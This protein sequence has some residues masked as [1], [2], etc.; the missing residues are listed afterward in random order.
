MSGSQ[1]LEVQL[2]ALRRDGALE[3]EKQT[4]MMR[5]KGLGKVFFSATPFPFPWEWKPVH[6]WTKSDDPLV[7]EF[8]EAGFWTKSKNYEP[9]AV[10]FNR[11]QW[12]RVTT[13][14]KQTVNDSAQV[15]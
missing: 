14:R 4:T 13:C 6:I 7:S 10:T 12:W 5:A 3:D 1:T 9:T 15:T 11:S 8:D 2:R